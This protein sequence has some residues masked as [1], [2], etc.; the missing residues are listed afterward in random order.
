MKKILLSLTVLTTLTA[1]SSPKVVDLDNKEEVSGMTNVM[2]LEYRDWVK[3][4]EKMTNTML[5]SGGF[6]KIKD[7]VIAMGPMKNET[8]QRFDT[9]FFT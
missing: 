9:E 5:K 2:E 6:A 4:S 1:C 8:M 3:T 7:P